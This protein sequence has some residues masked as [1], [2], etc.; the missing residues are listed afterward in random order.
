[1]DREGS[2]RGS[3]TKTQQTIPYT[4]LNI[5]QEE[6]AHSPTYKHWLAALDIQYTKM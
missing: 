4:K 1:M 3:T 2:T 6:R 5:C